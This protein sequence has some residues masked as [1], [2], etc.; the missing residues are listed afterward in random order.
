MEEVSSLTSA[1]PTLGR[2]VEWSVSLG[3]EVRSTWKL[4]GHLAQAGQ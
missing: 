2:R 4:P 1:S 3:L